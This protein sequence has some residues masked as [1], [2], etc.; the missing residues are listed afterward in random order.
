M[1]KQESKENKKVKMYKQL[2]KEKI[3][4]PLKIN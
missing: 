3:G 1:E 4:L 2:L